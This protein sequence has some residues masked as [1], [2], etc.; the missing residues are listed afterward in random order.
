VGF[1]YSGNGVFGK[2]PQRMGDNSSSF[3]YSICCSLCRSMDWL[4]ISFYSA[5]FTSY[6][7]FFRG[8]EEVEN[9]FFILSIKKIAKTAI[10]ATTVKTMRIVGS[11]LNISGCH[12]FVLSTFV[13]KLKL[14]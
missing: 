3:D 11:N 14:E 8:L 2:N 10:T 1:S 7:R 5:A 13:F 9:C 12:I 4:G 6:W